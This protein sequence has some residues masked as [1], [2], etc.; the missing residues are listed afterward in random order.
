MNQTVLVLA[1]RGANQCNIIHHSKADASIYKIQYDLRR[2]Q[3]VIWTWY[4][5]NNWQF[6]KTLLGSVLRQ[7]W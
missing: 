6:G 5:E 7:V 4:G 3:Q 2:K 1:L